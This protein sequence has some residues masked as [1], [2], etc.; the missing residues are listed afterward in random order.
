MKA[1]LSYR[2]WLHAMALAACLTPGMAQTQSEQNDPNAIR[3]LLSPDLETTLIAPMAGRINTLEARLGGSVAK[4]DAVIQFDCAE[5]DARLKM[6]KAE[7]ASTGA[8]LS[9][10][11][12]LRKLDAAGDTEVAVA[13]AEAERAKASVALAQAQI[14]H[15]TVSAPFDGRIVR[16]LVKPFQGVTAGMPMVELVSEGP[17]KI[18]LNVPSQWLSWLK[19]G[20]T[21]DV[22]VNETRQTYPAQV[23]AINARVDAVA[24]TIE[25]EARMVGEHPELLAGMSGIARFVTPE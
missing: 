18:R 22:A 17:L 13:S 16:V 5:A 14:E 10:K 11:V 12:R 2:P 9:A 20:T 23:T 24:Q 7:R 6:A 15:C 4:G 3:V 8:T 19:E 25:L 21:F 1:R